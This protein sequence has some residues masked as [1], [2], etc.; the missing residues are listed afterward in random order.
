MGDSEAPS[1]S[2][3]FDFDTSEPQIR[4]NNTSNR[5]LEAVLLASDVKTLVDGKDNDEEFEIEML[6]IVDSDDGDVVAGAD[7]C[8]SQG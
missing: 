4:P 8:V 1:F 7:V 2:L 5:V 6:T 3:G